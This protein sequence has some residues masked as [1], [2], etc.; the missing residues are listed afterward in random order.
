MTAH[1]NSL[2]ISA[3][4]DYE[5]SHERIADVLRLARAASVAHL[6]A[7]D[8]RAASSQAIFRFVLAFF[9][10]AADLFASPDGLD[11]LPAADFSDLFEHAFLPALKSPLLHGEHDAAVVA[12]A[13]EGV[14][15]C[16][17][18][19][20]FAAAV[21]WSH[22]PDMPEVVAVL[23]GAVAE[24]VSADHAFVSRFTRGLRAAAT[25]A[26][27]PGSILG[28]ADVRD[29][30]RA[31]SVPVRSGAEH[32]DESHPRAVN[33]AALATSLRISAPRGSNLALG[34]FSA[35]VRDVTGD[36][37]QRTAP[38]AAATADAADAAAE[39]ASRAK[40]ASESAISS[41]SSST[42]STL[43]ATPAALASASV[44]ETH[45]ARP[46]QADEDTAR[47]VAATKL[48][49]APIIRAREAAAISAS[50]A[51]LAASRRTGMGVTF[52]MAGT[53]A[54]ST[55]AGTA[56]TTTTLS[57]VGST[58]ASERQELGP[59]ALVALWDSGSAAAAEGSENSTAPPSA[60]RAVAEAAAAQGSCV[61]LR[62]ADFCLNS[63]PGVHAL[64]VLP[65]GPGAEPA[66]ACAA[67]S[68]DGF[69]FVASLGPA[70]S[71]WARAVHPSH[72][73]HSATALAV[74]LCDASGR[75][76]SPLSSTASS[77]ALHAPP[78]L[79]ESF[80][81]QRALLRLHAN[82][83]PPARPPTAIACA[84]A[85]VAA[86]AWP[87]DDG[88]ASACLWFWQAPREG[89]DTHGDD[90][91]DYTGSTD[92]SVD[93]SHVH[94]TAA[95][96]AAAATPA[97]GGATADENDDEEELPPA[98][99]KRLIKLLRSL[100]QDD[101]VT[102]VS[103]R[104]PPPPPAVE[105]VAI[106]A[107]PP[108]IAQASGGIASML[109][110]SSPAPKQTSTVPE[111]PA[112]SDPIATP[113]A[114]IE[115]MQAPVATAPTGESMLASA[116]PQEGSVGGSVPA[117]PTAL[118][119][120][121]AVDR[122]SSPPPRMRP[123]G[124]PVRTTRA[125]VAARVPTARGTR[126]DA[127]DAPIFLRCEG[128]F[129]PSAAPRLA[130]PPLSSRE[131]ALVDTLRERY[132]LRSMSSISLRATVAEADPAAT[133][134]VAG[135]DLARTL[136]RAGIAVD[137]A[138]LALLFSLLTKGCCMSF[139]EKTDTGFSAVAPSLTDDGARV[140]FD[141][142]LLIDLIEA[143]PATPGDLDT[144]AAD[145]AEDAEIAAFVAAIVRT[146]LRARVAAAARDAAAARAAFP[147]RPP[148][149]DVDEAGHVPLD[150]AAAV[151][152]AQIAGAAA[153][154]LVDG[155]PSFDA[156]TSS[157]AEDASAA[158][159][160][161]AICAEDG[162]A[163]VMD[164]EDWAAFL[165]A[166]GDEGFGVG[167]ARAASADAEWGGADEAVGSAMA[168][169]RLRNTNSDVKP[170]DAAESALQKAL[171]ACARFASHLDV[172]APL[173][174]RARA[175]GFISAAALR[176]ALEDELVICAPGVV[177]DEQLI[178]RVALLPVRDIIARYVDMGDAELASLLTRL[179]GA[180]TP[181]RAAAL[182]AALARAHALFAA[183]PL[184]STARALP[185][186]ALF[187]RN[188][189]SA[190]SAVPGLVGSGTETGTISR[191]DALLLMRRFAVSTA[192][193][194]PV[195]GLGFGVH[196]EALISC[197]CE[198]GGTS[199][200]RTRAAPMPAQVVDAHTASFLSSLTPPG[201]TVRV[202]ST[203]APA[204]RAPDVP[205]VAAINP[206]PPVASQAAA[207]DAPAWSFPYAP[208]PT[209]HAAPLEADVGYDDHSAVITAV[210][211][212]ST[213]ADADVP[214]PAPLSLAPLPPEA[215][216]TASRADRA[217]V[218]A[219]TGRWACAFC[220]YYMNAPYTSACL[221][222]TT[223][224]NLLAAQPAAPTF[225][226]TTDTSISAT[227]PPKAPAS[228]VFVRPS[229]CPVCDAPLAGKAQCGMCAY[230]LAIEGGEENVGATRATIVGI[231]SP[232]AVAAVAPV[233]PVRAAMSPMAFQ[234]VVTA[235]SSHNTSVPLMSDAV[236]DPW[237]TRHTRPRH[238]GPAGIDALGSST[239]PTSPAG[240][241][242]TSRGPFRSSAVVASAR[243]T[244][245]F[246]GLQDA[247][248]QGLRTARVDEW[249]SGTQAAYEAA[250][251]S[252]VSTPPRSTSKSLGAISPNVVTNV[253]ATTGVVHVKAFSSSGSAR[254]RLASGRQDFAH[255]QT[256]AAKL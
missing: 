216:P 229:M 69:R 32:D 231:P 183:S 45:A 210:S 113:S 83:S 112:S 54:I 165:R 172:A 250:R 143:P 100:L 255:L 67:Y 103:T 182:R 174:T 176:A 152:L 178:E 93:D 212:E 37:L 101:G 173:R 38:D 49:L 199:R 48:A 4:D 124:K 26:A 1:D 109:R 22:E 139:A 88:D 159:T 161:L 51:A 193:A 58:R 56:A 118:E 148:S 151:T 237:F 89:V 53:G 98:E 8:G 95:A 70:A 235:D 3:P 155:A 169:A 190:L 160:R 179:R 223:P 145:D 150:D 84:G 9:A 27:V 104:S 170:L 222:C 196:A 130:P 33:A 68:R 236:S 5:E 126:A 116:A 19:A 129:S 204:S 36:V 238:L 218:F 90:S 81:E 140:P 74:T 24:S 215:E 17:D 78:A 132:S 13:F 207:I 40:T 43:T 25:R 233:S 99:R 253:A 245:L 138:G 220:F 57:V 28:A 177:L 249:Q 200:R 66:A 71:L 82:A 128:L 46:T 41:L 123:A 115:A 30:L 114:A 240:T 77:F 181:A 251:R 239:M 14:D 20:A 137:G 241:P 166:R 194:P 86:G 227:A 127:A 11:V 80:P 162:A 164:T 96:N 189:L 242:S 61:S 60:R 185:T 248:A 213:V 202:F 158:A 154:A 23:R 244:P 234:N 63:V 105:P 120:V 142:L 2:N 141:A 224:H 117:A 175:D 191:T 157:S 6:A 209:D 39:A 79:L 232:A 221:M 187:S 64:L 52:N 76:K 91:T 147:A 198:G 107:S 15:G 108:R 225:G 144:T 34:H 119:V 171:R 122:P 167:L 168:G 85:W 10:H 226:D 256:R 18:A 135:A 208:Q 97:K 184:S 75:L 121:R 44:A 211:V 92:A 134:M 247:I 35:W 201:A 203:P 106:I 146:R 72:D 214:R 254:E 110:A 111:P 55:F 156:D 16:I 195:Q 136:A 205:H 50:K 31:L 131:A 228:A 149:R 192:V 163:I 153:A 125:T 87:T 59:E 12:R 102:A 47:L 7:K 219:A 73:R 188:L 230:E 252:G 243:E 197:L 246:D 186:N 94:S 62:A 29:L 180:A 206:S 217:A 42:K 21:A 65:R 133:G